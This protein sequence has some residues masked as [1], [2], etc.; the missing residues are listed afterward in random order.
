[1]ESYMIVPRL[2]KLPQD[3][4][5][6]Y[7]FTDVNVCWRLA[8]VCKY[9]HSL[10]RRPEIQKKIAQLEV[11]PTE[12]L[13]SLP[14]EFDSIDNGLYMMTHQIE[15]PKFIYNRMSKIVYGSLG[16]I[17]GRI[18][19]PWNEDDSSYFSSSTSP[20]FSSSCSCCDSDDENDKEDVQK[21][22]EEEEEEE[23]KNED[24]VL[25]FKDEKEVK[26]ERKEVEDEKEVKEEEEEEEEEG[27]EGEEN[28]GGYTTIIR[29][30]VRRR[31]RCIFYSFNYVKYTGTLCKYHP[32]LIDAV[33][34][35][36]NLGFKFPF[37]S[38]LQR[39]F[40]RRHLPL[41]I[42]EVYE[43]DVLCLISNGRQKKKC[44]EYTSVQAYLHDIVL[45]LRINHLV[46]K[47]TREA[48][49]IDPFISSGIRIGILM[50]KA[51]EDVKQILGRVVIGENN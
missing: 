12:Y 17:K 5:L 48:A 37:P 43:K 2:D 23:E 50:G 3:I 18:I 47:Y 21:D 38:F 19:N 25:D 46:N 11:S 45:D 8:R 40:A 42:R 9:F 24:G 41:D 1:M 32:T 35:A 7:F 28:E 10:S 44:C 51:L 30:Y 31:N 14:Q 29:L 34:Y 49:R 27:E 15:D 20:T 13:N 36:F 33:N 6:Y 22:D 4:L 39:I 26:V 16:F